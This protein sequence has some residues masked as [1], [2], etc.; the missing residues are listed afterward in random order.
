VNDRRSKYKEK[1]AGTEHAE[2]AGNLYAE[3]NRV[4]T[5]PPGMVS[6]AVRLPVL[7]SLQNLGKF[8]ESLPRTVYY[9][10]LPALA[11]ANLLS[12][13]QNWRLRRRQAL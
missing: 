13:S 10:Q 8:L 3:W 6:P 5:G 1:I 2:V 7:P 11:R 4:R 12:K 9:M